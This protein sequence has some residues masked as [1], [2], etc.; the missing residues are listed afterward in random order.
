[1]ENRI[2]Y[3]IPADDATAITASIST[4]KEK[5]AFLKGLSVDERSNLAKMAEK[6]VAFVDGALNHAELNPELRPSFFDLTAMQKDVELV[7]SLAPIYAEVAKLA[8]E[9][10]DT[11]MLA[12]SE[13]Y[14]A[15]LIFYNSVKLAA[16]YGLPG[17]V[18]IYNDL[19]VRFEK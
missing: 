15:A 16:R 11:M 7:K 17:A 12:G 3:Q 19:K 14:N 8:S 2:D 10:D 9:L 6:T 5:L 13:A 18:E 1:M 4:L